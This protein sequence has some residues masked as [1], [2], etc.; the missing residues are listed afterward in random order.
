MSNL[1]SLPPLDI[2]RGDTMP[3]RFQVSDLAGAIYDLTGWTFKMTFSSQKAPADSGS[4]TGQASADMSAAEDG[5][6]AFPRPALAVGTHYYDIEATDPDGY[7]LTLGIGVCKVAQDI[8]K[9]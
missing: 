9:T 3:F 7:K 4:Q 2:F 6:M 1:P 5:W 8:T